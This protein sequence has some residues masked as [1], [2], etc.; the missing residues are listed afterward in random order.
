M[1]RHSV[2][3]L[4]LISNVLYVNGYNITFSSRS[5][6]ST[7]PID[8]PFSN[9]INSNT[10]LMCYEDLDILPTA[11]FC[12]LGTL[13]INQQTI[14]WSNYSVWENGNGTDNFQLIVTDTSNTDFILAFTN[15][16]D[17]ATG[18]GKAVY[19]RINND[20]FTWSNH[21]IQF[22]E[23]LTDQ[24]QLEYLMNN[25][26]VICYSTGDNDQS[27][28]CRLGEYSVTNMNITFSKNEY[29]VFKGEATDGMSIVK[30]TN[31]SFLA[32]FA[33]G[34]NEIGGC[35]IGTV[36]NDFKNGINSEI[37]FNTKQIFNPN[38]GTDEVSI[39]FID[40]NNLLFC[41]VSRDDGACTFG[42]LSND[43]TEISF[44]NQNR[45]VFITNHCDE[46]DSVIIPTNS[47]NGSPLVLICYID[48][49]RNDNKGIC[50][51][52]SIDVAKYNIMFDE[53]ESTYNNEATD[54]VITMYL[55]GNTMIVCYLD[56]Q[57][58]QEA[59]NKGICNFGTFA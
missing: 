3:K 24:T 54:E 47:N 20:K 59:K 11:G 29:S 35:Y 18:P 21:Y 46:T 51:F 17:S 4:L 10:L 19:G 6:Y 8:T 50:R 43:K 12:K 13:N 37:K 15:G 58:E 23:G 30:L 27:I 26:F 40:E 55:G 49:S 32:C 31:I 2:V 5:Y 42:I 53:N 57:S 48:L 14:S 25:Y 38:G 36:Q 33:E 1:S 52:G 16:D 34:I 7:S 56:I 44:P 39:N 41:Y 22:N 45:N 28:M 9:L